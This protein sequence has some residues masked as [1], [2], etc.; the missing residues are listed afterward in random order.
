[1]SRKW[2]MS[3]CVLVAW[4]AIPALADDLFPPEWRG[5]PGSTWAEWE[6]STP[7]PNPLPDASFN[8]YGVPQTRVYP[9]VGQV[10]W[11]ILNGRQGVWPLSGEIWIDIPNQD[12]PNPWKDIYIQLTWAPQA[13]GNSPIVQSILPMMVGGTL[14]QEIPLEGAW[15]HSIYTIRLEPNPAWEQILISGG[16]DVDQ[17][18]IDTICVPEPAAM[19]LLALGG[20]V[21]AR[22]R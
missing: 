6:Y 14:V 11:D 9:G 17:V 12:K 22:R 16:I 20:L 2:L 18:V 1:M 21:F 7:N 13:P 15:R 10:W 4:T 19:L 3:L 5:Q 8:P